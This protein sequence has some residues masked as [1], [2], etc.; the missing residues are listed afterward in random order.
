VITM[1][2]TRQRLID[3]A[4]QAIRQHG[5]TGT[6]ART[7]ATAA[8]VNQAL[9]FYHFG[10]VHELL[11]QACLTATGARVAP[12]LER[13]DEVTTLRELLDLGRRLHAEERELGNVMVLAQV[14]AGA[15]SDPSLAKATSAALHL[16]I[17]PIERTL[18]RVLTGSPLAALVDTGGLA[19]AVC[20]GFIGL[21]LF[22]GVE[23]VGA[24]SALDA[25]DRMAALV[26]VIDDLGPVAR[27]ALRAKLRRS[28]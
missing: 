10:S 25:L 15:Q 24:Q 1:A 22:E 6:S 18:D 11:E 13:L 3:G 17:D 4:I 2:D 16:W 8:G 21:E 23:P 19:R 27:R 9:V 5:I 20:A 28:T 12:F 7:I 14:L 26:E